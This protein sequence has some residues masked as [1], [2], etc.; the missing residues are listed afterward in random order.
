MYYVPII[1]TIICLGAKISRCQDASEKVLGQY[2]RTLCD[3]TYVSTISII[4]LASYLYVLIV[5]LGSL[6]KI[7]RCLQ[8]SIRTIPKD[9]VVL[10]MYVRLV[11]E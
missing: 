1:G 9:Y 11:D 7:S 6:A 2:I 3:F 8:E 10:L 5:L 4:I